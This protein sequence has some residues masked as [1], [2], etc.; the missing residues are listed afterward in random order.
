MWNI[1]KVIGRHTRQSQWN[2]SSVFI[3]NFEH[4]SNPFYS[5]S[6]VDFE[7]VINCLELNKTSND[8]YLISEIQS[9]LDM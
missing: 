3:V 2:H 1:F 8:N 9:K 6:I 4:I 7:H 5:A